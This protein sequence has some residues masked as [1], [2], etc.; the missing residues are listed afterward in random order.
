M[1]SEHVQG[2]E[3]Y[4]VGKWRDISEKL[5]PRWDDQALRL[6]AARLLGAQSLARYIGWQGSK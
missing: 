1:M 3:K 2:L 6:K 5:L 4:G